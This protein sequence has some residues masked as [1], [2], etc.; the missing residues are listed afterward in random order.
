MTLPDRLVQL[1]GQIRAGHITVAQALRAQVERG[2]MLRTQV[3]CVVDT[4]PIAPPPTGAAAGPLAGIALAHKDIFDGQ[5][6]LP[7]CGVGHGQTQP[8]VQAAA[9]VAALAQ[10]G[11]SQWATLV[12]APHAC[13][14]TAQNPHFERCV[15]PLDKDAA[16][17]GSSSGA[18]VAVAAGMTY[19]ALGT[20]TAGSVRIPAASCGLIGLKTTHGAVSTQGCAPLAP[21]LDS[22][23]V[24][25]R[26]AEDARQI[27]QALCPQASRTEGAS[28]QA[29]GDWRCQLWLPQTEVQPEVSHAIQDWVAQR[30]LQGVPVDMADAF[31]QL[32][33][34][35]Q[36][37]LFYETARTHRAALLAGHADAA[38]QAIG[39]AG[40]A[41]P[42]GWYQESLALRAGFL[43]QFVARH[44]AQADLLIL[45][46]LACMLPDWQ[47]VEIGHPAFDRRAL[48]ALHAFMGFVNY[49]GLPA[50][51]LPIARDA[52]QRPL[53]VQ[54]L[55]RPFAEHQLLDFANQFE[56]KDR[57]F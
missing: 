1:Q 33:R 12:M 45:P 47:T 46:S 49:L 17:G 53:C 41:I 36:R 52:R 22:I 48:A 27:W 28:P 11:A 37:V 5:D 4:L 44:F 43:A 26:D 55:A 24:L 29:A 18:A 32:N 57:V 10:A 8:G 21:A 20:D 50:L 54:V 19:A 16:V 40:L 14:A 7:G 56:L 2:Q 51:N 3:A 23:G 13:G 39:E 6:R 35:A 9:A 30:G 25:S 38:V 31:A 34:Y 42:D 15:N